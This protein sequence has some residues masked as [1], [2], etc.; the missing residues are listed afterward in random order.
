MN[1]PDIKM[2]NRVSVDFHNAIVNGESGLL[3][4]TKIISHQRVRFFVPDDK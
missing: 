2:G 3:T 1:N 4:N